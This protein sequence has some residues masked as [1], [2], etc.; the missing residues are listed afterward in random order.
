[1]DES[2]FEQIE[3]RNAELDQKKSEIDQFASKVLVCVVFLAN[4]HFALLVSLGTNSWIA[5][6]PPKSRR[7]CVT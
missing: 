6:M 5:N 4:T 7:S 1:M 3:K 2:F